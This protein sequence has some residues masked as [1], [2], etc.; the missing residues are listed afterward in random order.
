LMRAGPRQL[1]VYSDCSVQLREAIMEKHIRKGQPKK[2]FKWGC[3]QASKSRE[4][5]KRFRRIPDRDQVA[6]AVEM[7]IAGLKA[8][9]GGGDVT[10]ASM[11]SIMVG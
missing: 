9:E 8:N 5:H 1:E 2:T 3:N 10:A 6:K 4:W 11:R 7:H